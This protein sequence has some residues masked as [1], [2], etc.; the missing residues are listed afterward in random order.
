[1]S[2][3]LYHGPANHDPA[4]GGGVRIATIG[5]RDVLIGGAAAVALGLLLGGKAQAQTADKAAASI[6]DA[7]K[8]I[9]GDAKPV[10]GKI[11]LD[12][13]EIA[14]NGNTVPF[15]LSADSPMTDQQY[16][17]AL[18]ILAAG[19]PQLDVAIFSFTPLAGKA[20]V[21]SRMRLAKS[22]DVYAVAALSDG[23][24]LVAKR[25]VKVTIGGCGG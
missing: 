9:M 11:T 14:E 5:R 15:T 13:P 4:V 24:F 12:L 25:M 8:G 18:H 3:T 20:S 17:K 7:L 16:V 6:D 10:D 2:Q 19:N 22:Q 23:K 21:T 1:M